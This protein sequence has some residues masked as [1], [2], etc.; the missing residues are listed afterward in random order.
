MGRVLLVKGDVK[1]YYKNR[2]LESGPKILRQYYWLI[3]FYLIYGRNNWSAGSYF[4]AGCK[5]AGGQNPAYF[6]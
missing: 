6:N 2:V 1:T 3:G 5:C 4:S